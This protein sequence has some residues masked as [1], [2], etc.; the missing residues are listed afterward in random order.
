MWQLKDAK[1]ITGKQEGIWGWVAVNE[2]L[3]M[4]APYV[5]VMDMGG[6]SVQ[7]TYPLTQTGAVNPNDKVTLSVRGQTVHLFV[8]SFLGLGQTE[9]MHQLLDEPACYAPGY[10]MIDDMHIGKGDWNACESKMRTLMHLHDVASVVVPH[11]H[12]AT[13]PSWY[14]I[15]GL[16]F[17]VNKPMLQSSATQIVI[18]EW[19]RQARALFCETEW[20]ELSFMDPSDI[21]LAHA[22]LSS[23]Y[24]DVLLTKGY[25]FGPQQIIQMSQDEAADSWALGVV[26]MQG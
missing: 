17:L 11:L 10:E 25:G 23:A 7:I 13:V 21:Y 3:G 12:Q 2:H 26:V 16:S 14:T 5:G 18:G 24:Y 15:G 6:A 22:C 19:M 8:H 1:T 20:S 9:V 4:K